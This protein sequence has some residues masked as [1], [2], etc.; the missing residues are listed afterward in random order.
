MREAKMTARIFKS[1]G[2]EVLRLATSR[3]LS[4]I[5]QAFDTCDLLKLCKM[6]QESVNA[7]IMFSGRFTP[8]CQFCA[9]ATAASLRPTSTY[10]SLSGPFRYRVNTPW[11]SRS[12]LIEKFLLWRQ[13]E[14]AEFRIFQIL[15]Y[16]FTQARLSYAIA[17]NSGQTTRDTMTRAISEISTFICLLPKLRPI[18][19]RI[20]CGAGVPARRSAAS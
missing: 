8:V 14:Q 11:R 4:C 15:F 1:D 6:Q 9:I 10:L 2:F 17:K 19:E 16:P 5:V 3:E 18:M 13:V 7:F 12:F 20:S